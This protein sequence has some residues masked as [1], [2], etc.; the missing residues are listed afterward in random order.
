MRK[1]DLARLQHWCGALFVVKHVIWFVQF[2]LELVF[3]RPGLNNTWEGGGWGYELYH[4]QSKPFRGHTELQKWWRP[5]ILFS[6]YLVNVNPV[7]QTF[8]C[9]FQNKRFSGNSDTPPPSPPP[10][11]HTHRDTQIHVS[12]MPIMHITIYN[13]AACVVSRKIMPIYKSSFRKLLSS[14]V[15]A[16]ADHISYNSDLLLEW[17]RKLR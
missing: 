2:E 5:A 8:F 15:P 16:P 4:M 7:N 14:T 6:G 9:D 11:S 3:M 13:D 10:P 1:V 12:H 17:T